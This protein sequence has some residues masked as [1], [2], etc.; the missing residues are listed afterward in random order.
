MIKVARIKRNLNNIAFPRLSGTEFELKAFNKIKKE[1]ENLN[2]DYQVQGFTFSSFYSRLYPKIMFL[3]VS[4]IFLLFYIAVFIILP[5]ILAIILVAIVISFSILTRKPEKIQIIPKFKSQNLL[6]KINSKSNDIKNNNRIV[7]FISHLDSKGQRWKIKTRIRVI[8]LWTH[9]SII[10]TVVL[11]IKFLINLP[12]VIII[13]I[14]GLVP[15]MLN[16]FAAIMMLLNTTN[17]NSDG[18]TDNGSGVV[19]NLEMLNYFS[20]PENRLKNY[21]MWVLFTG[22]EECGTMGIRHFYN[23]LKNFDPNISIIFNFES[24]TS[25]IILFPGGEGDH[26]KD[27]NYLLLNNNRKLIIKNT[28]TKRIF[29]THSDGGF[30]GDRGLQGFGI[31]GA[32]AHEYM[33]S[34]NDTIDKVNTT[35]LKRLC[36]VLTDALKEHDIKFFK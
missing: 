20:I 28:T 32:G 30:L 23:N 36:L 14:L 27:I 29:G 9:T 1:V 8:K 11:I 17:N 21:N 6:V 35:I 7:L 4:L 31:G 24:V 33:H 18:A 16:I 19:C 25:L 22:A 26:I 10:L 5:L 2:L 12:F 34:S 15:L 13:H 3:S